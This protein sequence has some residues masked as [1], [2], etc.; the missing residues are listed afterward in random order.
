M[1]VVR[2]VDI[3]TGVGAP[4]V[5]EASCGSGSMNEKKL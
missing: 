5:N 1:G 3:G 2:T 4:E